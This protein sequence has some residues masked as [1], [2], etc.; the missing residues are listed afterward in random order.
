MHVVVVVD[1]DVAIAVDVDAVGLRITQVKLGNLR[2]VIH[3]QNK[4]SMVKRQFPPLHGRTV[5]NDC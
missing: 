4:D 1:A 5:L 2:L 3:L